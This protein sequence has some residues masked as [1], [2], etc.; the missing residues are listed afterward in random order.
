M[1]PNVSLVTFTGEG[2][3]QIL[4]SSCVTDAEASVIRDLQL[5]APGTTCEPDPP[6]ARPA[7]WDDVPV[8]DGVG[9]LVDDPAIDLALG[10]P[11]TQV[12]ADVWH[13]SGDPAAVSAGL[14]GRLRRARL[15]GDRGA[16][17]CSTGATTLAAF[18]PDGTQ[19]VILIIPPDALA[20]QPGSRGGG[21]A[22]RSRPGIRGRRRPRRVVVTPPAGS[23][24]VTVDPGSDTGGPAGSTP[25][26]AATASHRSARARFARR[27]SSRLTATTPSTMSARTAAHGRPR[28]RTETT[29]PL[30]VTAHRSIE[31]DEPRRRAEGGGSQP[32]PPRRR[33][34]CPCRRSELDSGGGRRRH[35]S[36]LLRL[37]W[38]APIMTRGCNS[39]LSPISRPCGRR[40][41]RPGRSSH[42]L[43]HGAPPARRAGGARRRPTPRS[44]SRP[45]ARR[46]R[47]CVAASSAAGRP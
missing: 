30:G 44:G 1:G 45:S 39:R 9:P 20:S 5:P 36:S 47:G 46:H 24:G 25:T 12:Y 2:H 6:V 42:S 11:P 13:L 8:P 31:T 41:A 34:E 28:T 14:P 32:E 4:S 29:P 22:R 35:H 23:A 15:R 16:R 43:R 17:T 33:G 7:F 3:G 26:W 21:R 27:A 18:A 40:P 37:L 19:V 10:L 38:H